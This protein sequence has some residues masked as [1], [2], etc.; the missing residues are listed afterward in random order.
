MPKT[1]P[2]GADPADLTFQLRALADPVRLRVLT[3][4]LRPDPQC[5]RSAP[6]VCACDIETFL[7]LSQPTVSHHMKVLVLA[8]L[9]RATKRGRWVYYRLN[10]QA[11]DG[12]IRFLQPFAVASETVGSE[13]A[14][15]GY[16]TANHLGLQ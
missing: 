10:P 3:F 4:L 12:L 6:D 7:G 1:I 8:G 2:R 16:Q 11:F 15:N 13:T 9:V 5:C 14:D